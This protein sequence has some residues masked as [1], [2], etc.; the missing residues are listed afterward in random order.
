MTR[1]KRFVAD[2]GI[3]VPAVTA[4]QM[5]EIDRIAVEDTGPNLFQMMENAGRNLALQSIKLLGTGWPDAHIVVLAGSGGNG[6]GAVCAARHL[7]N[8][9]VQVT[10]ASTG[11]EPAGEVLRLQRK[12]FQLTSGREA[13]LTNVDRASVDLIVDGVVG[14]SLRGAP[15]GAAREM[16]QWANETDAPILALDVPSGVDATTGECAGDYVHARSTLTLAL[17]KTGLGPAETGALYLADIGIPAGVYER[18]GLEYTPPFGDRFC[19]P[20]RPRE[21]ASE[22]DGVGAPRS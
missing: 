14:Y 18:I 5:R 22:Q 12:I 19:V 16:I 10:L 2:S 3:E 4:D 21:R 8:R 20:L 6:G 9:G 11:G 13:S 1:F 17:P 15:T 7:A